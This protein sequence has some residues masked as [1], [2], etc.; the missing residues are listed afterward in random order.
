MGI[1]N[2]AA[3]Y[4]GYDQEPY[5]MENII[6]N[7]LINRGYLINIGAITN[8]ENINGKPTKVTREVD[9]IAEKYGRRFYIQSA[10]LIDNEEKLKQEK[11]SFKRIKDTFQRVIINKYSS[12]TFYDEDGTLR[13]GLLDFLL[14]KDKNLI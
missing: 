8:A 6:Y 2:A 14:G 9:F 3:F 7:E 1:G 10:Y 4:K 5:F 12:G 11:E 13:I